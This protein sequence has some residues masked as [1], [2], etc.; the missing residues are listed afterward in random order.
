[1]RFEPKGE[2]RTFMGERA[3]FRELPPEKRERA[4][5]VERTNRGRASRDSEINRNPERAFSGEILPEHA[6]EPPRSRAPIQG[7]EPNF[8]RVP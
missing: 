2:E 3:V 8:S 4:V 5:A 6:S 1:M 7:S